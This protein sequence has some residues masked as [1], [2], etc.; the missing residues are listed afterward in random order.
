MK[1]LSNLVSRACTIYGMDGRTDRHMDKA[2]TIWSPFGELRSYYG[3]YRSGSMIE[4]NI[5]VLKVLV[6]GTRFW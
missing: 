3:G 5:S 4:Y 1:F 2:A 6:L